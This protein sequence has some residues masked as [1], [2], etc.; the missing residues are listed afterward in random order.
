MRV[1]DLEPR[2]FDGA[3]EVN[4]LLVIASE[5]LNGSSFNRHA[6]TVPKAKRTLLSVSCTG[7]QLPIDSQEV[8]YRK[9]LIPYV[10]GTKHS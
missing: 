4:D 10:P 3:E 6:D 1:T 8:A 2:C 9:G 7:H 5:C